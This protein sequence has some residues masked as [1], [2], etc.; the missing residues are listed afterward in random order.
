MVLKIKKASLPLLEYLVKLKIILINTKKYLFPKI[1]DIIIRKGSQKTGE[2]FFG[3]CY[4]GPQNSKTICLFF[5]FFN[6]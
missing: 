1:F 6:F 4:S 5:F 3:S 2:F